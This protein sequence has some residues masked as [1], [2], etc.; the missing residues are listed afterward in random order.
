MKRKEV[1][2]I[3]IMVLAAPAAAVAGG[4]RP[5]H[6][7][8]EA[9]L[10]E[11]T[12]RRNAPAAA[13][14]LRRSEAA[15][16]FVSYRGMK[17][18]KFYVPSVQTVKLKVVHLKPDETRTDYFAPPALAG[19]TVIQDGDNLWRYLP[20]RC[21]WER[22][23]LGRPLPED[24][25][26]RAALANYDLRLAGT[27][28]VA[29]RPAYVI[30]AYPKHPGERAHQVW[31]DK[32]YY[33]TIATEADSPDGYVINSSRYTKIEFNPGD[34]SPSVFKVTGKIKPVRKTAA[35]V[36]FKILGPRYI[37]RGY[38]QV[39][40]ST[41]SVNGHTSVCMQ[42]SNG[43]DTISFFERPVNCRCKVPVIHSRYTRVMTWTRRNMAYTL[44]GDLSYAELHKIANSIK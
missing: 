42:F 23:R 27:D 17:I 36:K 40:M 25:I 4:G 9:K 37:P 18:V 3:L 33:V 32:R 11:E 22:S 26:R 13:E 28:V 24:M 20:C 8:R 15:D 16:R 1:A 39:S 31:I 7:P 2:A 41:L 35:P 30:R 34:I 29:G 43:A 21:V 19:V 14:V 5:A 12:P 44:I 6:P 10:R 38:A